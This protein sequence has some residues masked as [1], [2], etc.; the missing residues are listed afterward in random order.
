MAIYHCSIKIIGRGKG[1]SAVRSAAYRAGEKIKNDYDGQTYDY[2]RKGGVVHTEILLPEHAPREYLDRAVLWNAVESIES[3]KNAQ[4]AREIEI[5]LPVELS[6]EQ[7]ISLA[8]DFVTKHF[9]SAGMCADVCVHDTGNGNPHAHV[10]LTMRPINESGRWGAKSKKEYI[11]DDNGERIRLPSGEYRSRQIYLTDW[12][13][14]SKPEEWREGWA[15]MLNEHLSR[16]GVSES[17]DHRSYTRQGIDK[18]PTIHL[19]VAASRMERKGIRT[20]R[21]DINRAIQLTNNHIRQLRARISKL[22]GWLAVNAAEP[23]LQDVV[24]SILDRRE[25]STVSRIKAAADIL[26]FLTENSISDMEGLERKVS[27]MHGEIQMIRDE[28]KPVERRKNTLDKHIEQA[29]IYKMHKAVHDKYRQEQNP[30]RRNAFYQK[31]T[32]GIILFEA[33]DRYLEGVLNGRTTIPIK[34][35]KA[36]RAEKIIERERLT[37]KYDRLKGETRKIE[38]IKR[39]V[40]DMLRGDTRERASKRVR[41]INL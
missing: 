38:Q 1:K 15:D 21:G 19:G 2:T 7:N 18:V 41:D 4:L 31:H 3:K 28:L 30:K 10:M 35:W 24:S 5:A 16:H 27:S 17:V 6:L 37:R 36:E 26:N 8:H 33:V 12:H 23:N 32:A 34:A 13:D 20:E 22:K 25:G 39:S 14:R 11:L 29:E 9:V 40:E